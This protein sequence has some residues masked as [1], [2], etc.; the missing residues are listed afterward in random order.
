MPQTAWRC[1]HPNGDV[2]YAAR[3]D[4][5]LKLEAKEYVCTLDPDL[6]M[7][8]ITIYDDLPTGLDNEQ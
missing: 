2:K 1:E 5:V 4:H 3:Y 6:D 8:T 7:D